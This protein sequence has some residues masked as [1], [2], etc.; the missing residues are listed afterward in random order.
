M[1]AFKGEARV[2][3]HHR[4][5]ALVPKLSSQATSSSRPS[6]IVPDEITVL[7]L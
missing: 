3:G 2:S 5:P 6:R 1:M 7:S 4:H